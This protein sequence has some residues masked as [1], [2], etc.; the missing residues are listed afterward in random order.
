MKRDLKEVFGSV[1]R[2]LREERG[3]SQQEL[4]DFSEVDR[5]YISD[6]ERGLYSP[7]LNTIYKLAEVLKLKPHELIEKVDV[8]MKV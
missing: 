3:L 7:S 6:L 2:G 5:T 4:A 1:I 8:L